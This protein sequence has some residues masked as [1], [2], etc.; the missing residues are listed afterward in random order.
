MSFRLIFTMT[1]CL[2]Y[3]LASHM[4][5]YHGM[6]KSRVAG[7]I[8]YK[9]GG[10]VTEYVVVE[11]NDNNDRTKEKLYDQKGRLLGF[12][13]YDY[14]ENRDLVGLKWLDPSGNILEETSYHHKDGEIRFISY[15]TPQNKEKRYI[16]RIKTYDANKKIVLT[17][18]DTH[19]FER[20]FIGLIDF[21][22]TSLHY[23]HSKD[24]KIIR[25][26][27]EDL[28]RGTEAKLLYTKIIRYADKDMIWNILVL[29]GKNFPTRY[30]TYQYTSDKKIHSIQ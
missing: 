10:I 16:S 12:Y 18:T 4:T 25:S 6:E 27:T 5:R 13:E 23:T 15:K 20:Q 28:V 26:Y 3:L 2:I 1:L 22:R 17:I 14:N 7:W 11:Y 19:S 21:K 29:D 9:P 8:T 24:K 30:L